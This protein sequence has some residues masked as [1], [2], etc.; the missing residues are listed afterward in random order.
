MKKIIFKYLCD[1]ILLL[2]LIIIIL[3][4]LKK[5]ILYN[6]STKISIDL[7]V[8]L[9]PATIT[10][11]SVSLSLQKEEEHGISIFTFNKIRNPY[12]Y[13]L[14]HMSIIMSSLILIY[15][16]LKLFDLNISILVLDCISFIYSLI[17]IFTEIP[18]LTRTEKRINKIIVNSI[19]KPVS[20]NDIYFDDKEETKRAVLYSI[21][22]EG[23][24]SFYIKNST[25]NSSYNDKLIKRLHDFQREYFRD[26][27]EN[28]EI[29]SNNYEN[30][31]KKINVIDAIVGAYS[32]IVDVYTNNENKEIDNY[33][34]ENYFYFVSLILI[35]HKI[36]KCINL[37]QKEKNELTSLV[38]EYHFL[39]FEN[40]YNKLL[41]LF[42]FNAVENIKSGDLWFIYLI[43]DNISHPRIVF[44]ENKSVLG[45]FIIIYM[46]FVINKNLISDV[47]KNKYYEFINE[48]TR[49]LNSD[50]SS[51]KDILLSFI[52][53]DSKDLSNIIFSLIKYF[54]TIDDSY[55]I[56]FNNN[57]SVGS[58]NFNKQSIIDAWLEIVLYDNSNIIL[59]DLK[60]T[61]S[62]F[63]SDLMGLLVDNLKNNWIVDNKIKREKLIFLNLIDIQIDE[64]ATDYYNNEIIT[65]LVKLKNDYMKEK[66]LEKINNENIDHKK[67]KAIVKE[68]FDNYI[69]NNIFY[70]SNINIE[71]EKHLCFVFKID[72]DNSKQI[73]DAY[74]R[75]LPNSIDYMLK[76]DIEEYIKPD[77]YSELDEDI[78]SKIKEYENGFCGYI[79]YSLS[80]DNKFKDI[81][82]KINRIDSQII[83]QNFFF[84]KDAIKL[85]I[86][87]DTEKTSIRNINEEEINT[88]IDSECPVI[89]GYYKYN[90]YSNDDKESIL[91]TREELKEMLK[92]NIS[93]F[94]IVFRKK[95]I[96]NKNDCLWLKKNDD[97]VYK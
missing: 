10:I 55:Y 32:N 24:V 1:I 57:T 25:K 59:N 21:F 96:I 9:L 30:S 37:L 72:K 46:S 81:K 69:N 79:R 74:I 41:P 93:Y 45:I 48:S 3:L 28:I 19:M 20:L 13:T 26:L 80:G 7:I 88:Y 52:A 6:N 62:L 97:Q 76:K 89:N 67:Y 12:R 64:I 38:I 70:D 94:F 23:I 87:L 83:P 29:I 91:Y 49:G 43:R 53:N 15:T 58:N 66:F 56:I 34:K 84:K 78:F 54:D 50:G 18:F 31:F 75:Q 16:F 40:E 61:I 8:I 82:D 71:S 39:T 51:W 63:D 11:L 65:Y 85:K 68:E 86:E 5:I 47:E 36:C 2:I 92:L 44:S 33:S 73:L 42:V 90:R 35:L 14:L 4:E 60:K 27:S 95:I 22:K 77:Y 17:F